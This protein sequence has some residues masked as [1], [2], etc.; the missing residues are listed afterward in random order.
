M[1]KLVTRVQNLG[2]KAAQLQQALKSVPP[3]IAEIREAVA[4]TTGELQ[5]LRA[6]VQSSV[7]GLVAHDTAGL[8]QALREINGGTEVFQQAGYALAGVD[9]E[10]SPSQRLTVHLA[11]LEHADEATLKSLIAANQSRRTVSALLSALLRAEEMAG[12]MQLTGLV[13]AELAVHIGPSP[14]VRMGWRTE[15]AVEATAPPV[16][17]PQV[18]AAPTEQPGFG[19]SSFFEKRPP[20]QVSP[21]AAASGPSPSAAPAALSGSAVTPAEAPVENAGQPSPAGWQKDA[22]ERFK[23]EPHYSK[24]GR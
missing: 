22:L 16:F 17:P 13:Y 10:L 23:K 5:Q 3:K 9:L 18:P 19:Q 2:Q 21:A 14:T 6:D 11:R 4:L 24:Y 20:Q 15:L 8:S 12:S 1:K 7:A